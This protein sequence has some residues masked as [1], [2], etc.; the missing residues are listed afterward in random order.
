MNAQLRF[1]F[2]D[3]IL[4][5]LFHLKIILCSSTISKVSL[6]LSTY[7]LITHSVQRVLPEH[8]LTPL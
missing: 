2:K 6:Y 4:N 8:N 5:N 3:C 1:Y 7:F